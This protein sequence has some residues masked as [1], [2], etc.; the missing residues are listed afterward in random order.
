METAIE[1]QVRSTEVDFL[2]HVNNANY[3]EPPELRKH[4]TVY[5]K[6]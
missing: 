3:L 1:I 5:Y 6:Q 4:L 2:G